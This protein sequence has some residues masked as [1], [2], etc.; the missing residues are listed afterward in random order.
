MHN[1]VDLEISRLKGQES[2]MIDLRLGTQHGGVEIAVA[3]LTKI[4]GAQVVMPYIMKMN[5]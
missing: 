3:E 1:L 4:L 2:I 5:K